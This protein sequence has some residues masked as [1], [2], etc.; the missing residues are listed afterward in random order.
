MVTVELNDGI[1]FPRIFFGNVQAGVGSSGFGPFEIPSLI[2][3]NVKF[4]DISRLA[5][6]AHD[7]GQA[8]IVQTMVRALIRMQQQQTYMA[9]VPRQSTITP[10]TAPAAFFLPMTNPTATHSRSARATYRTIAGSELVFTSPIQGDPSSIWMTR[11]HGSQQTLLAHA[12]EMR[13]PRAIHLQRAD[14]C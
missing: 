7:P 6:L 8:R 10:P 12:Q 9:V 4:L 5:Q 3:E 13:N 11:T 2:N 14:R 1:K